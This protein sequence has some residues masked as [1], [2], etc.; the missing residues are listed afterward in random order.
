MKCTDR[1]FNLSKI[2]QAFLLYN[3]TSL[4]SGQQS[5]HIWRHTTSTMKDKIFNSGTEKCVFLACFSVHPFFEQRFPFFTALFALTVRCSQM[6]PAYY[7]RHPRGLIH[8]LCILL[9]FNRKRGSWSSRA[10]WISSGAYDDQSGCRCRMTTSVSGHHPP[11]RPG[12]QVAIWTVKGK[13]S[14]RIQFHLSAWKW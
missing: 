3:F 9:C 1:A 12:T 10:C 2:L 5:S 7:P 4:S 6:Y 14:R 8:M 11:L 13:L